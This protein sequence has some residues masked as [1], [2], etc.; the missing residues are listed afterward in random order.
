MN[1][2]D[3]SLFGRVSMFLGHEAGLID[4]RDWHGWLALYAADA[5][6]WAPAWVDDQN[7]TS[8]P[9]RQTSLIYADRTELESRVFRIESEDSYAS[10]PLPQ[11]VHVVTCTHV[12]IAADGMAKAKANWIVHSFWR[13]KGAIVR[14]GRYEY[15]LREEGAGFLIALK[16][17]F[18]HDDRVAGPIDIYNI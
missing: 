14:A 6:F 2:S 18:V 7:M 4:S 9:T 11:T 15:E 13:T 16:K 12:E 3:N 10:M 17:I 1:K 8:D 5:N